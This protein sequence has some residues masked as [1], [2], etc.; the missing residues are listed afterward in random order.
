MRR[1]TV[2]PENVE[3]QSLFCIKDVRKPGYKAKKHWFEKQYREGL[4]M[5]LLKEDPE[6]LVGF[7]EYIPATH[8]WRPV[9]APGY[10]FI[11]CMYIASR[12]DRNQGMASRLI[13]YCVEEARKEGLGGVCVMTSKGTWLADKPVF[14]KNGFEVMDAR[15]RFELLALQWEKGLPAPELK[16]WTK[17]QSQY[18][19]WHLLYAN[20]C[21]WHVKSVEAIAEVALDYEID[22]Q[23]RELQT[24]AEARLAP[25]GYGVF[26]L[27][28]DGRLLEDHYI[29]ATRFR[30]ILKK[31]ISTMQAH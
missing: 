14:L 21:P 2:T 6:R 20:Q 8:A 13:T 16:D 27:L 23:I 9:E 25:S 1:I 11:H 28:H 31:E 12:K 29:S 10:M 3:E 4:R 5:M 30:N 22:L 17:S 19:G 26:A 24:P 18:Q 15:G 7:I